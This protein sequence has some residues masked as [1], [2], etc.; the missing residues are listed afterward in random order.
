MNTQLS[1]GRPA[2]DELGLIPGKK[3]RLYR[4]LYQHGLRNGTA[5]FLPY[6]HGLEHGPRDFTGHPE[7]GDPV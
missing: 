5:M 1:T 7:G 6:D 4:I 3:A 2:L